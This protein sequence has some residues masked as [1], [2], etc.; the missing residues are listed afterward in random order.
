MAAGK[1]VRTKEHKKK[2]SKVL[3]GNESLKNRVFTKEHREKIS[4]ALRGNSHGAGGKGMT[5]T[6]GHKDKLRSARKNQIVA[7][8][9]NHWNWRGGISYLPYPVKF[10]KKLKYKIRERDEFVCC[11]CDKTESEELEELNRALCVNHIDFDKN[12]CGEENLNTL[13]LRCNFKINRDR[14]YW[15]N[16]FNGGNA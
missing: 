8:G 4:V 15:T 3:K 6:Q 13:C 2:M 7:S 1:Y 12:N 11:L 10:N 14:K 5:K 16:Y 9:E